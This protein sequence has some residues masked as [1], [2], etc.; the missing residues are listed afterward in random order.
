MDSEK[1][2]SIRSI[3]GFNRYYTNILGLLD[4]HM[5]DSDFSL[6][7]IRVLYEIGHHENCT[8]K[9]LIETIRIDSG[10]LSRMIKRFEK[11]GLAYRTQ[12]GEDGRVY[13]LHLTEE[14]H[15]IL[16]QMDELSDQQIDQMVG[17]LIVE[18]RQKL[19]ESMN[20]I[21]TLLSGEAPSIAEE[22]TFRSDLR[23]GDVG[24]LISLHGML[25][26]KECGYNHM[27]EGYVCKTFYNFF[28]NYSPDKDRFW[29]AESKG[30]II[31]AVAIV[32][33]TAEKAQL[34]WFILDPEYRGRGYGNRLLKEALQYCREKKYTRVFLETT[35]DQKTAIRMYRQAGFEKTSERENN[36]WGRELNEQ[37]FEL[38]L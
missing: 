20:S 34:R 17:P 32:G 35:E 19:V 25:Y 7:E 9:S 15:K 22:V 38:K 24:R 33:H 1:T 18:N 26:Y 21:K 5:L 3:R 12:S 30:E 23:P 2:A 27:F 36:G 37:T 16:M 10:Y 6:S 28:Q 8:S 14:G 13:Y 31:G 4:K 29:F 11:Q